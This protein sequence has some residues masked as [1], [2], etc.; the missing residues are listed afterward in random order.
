MRTTVAAACAAL[1]VSALALPAAAADPQSLP[2]NTIPVKK[3]TLFYPGESTYEWLLSPAHEKANVRV[4]QGRS[5]TSCH[6]E[7]DTKDLGDKLVKAGPLE[8]NPIPGKKGTIDLQVQAAHDAEYLYLRAQWK[9][10]MNREG[11]MHDYVRFDGQKW[12]WYGH[13]RNDKKVRSGAEP[14]LYEDRF[15][16]MLDD[17]KVARFAE[18]GCWL[19][20]HNGMRDTPGQALGDPVKRHPLLGD[21]GLKASD[22]RKYLPSTRTGPD[23]RWDQTRSAEEIA[24]LKADGAFL[25]LMQWR[26]AR[27]APVGMADDGYVL[28]YRNFDDG[29]N[30]FSGNMDAKTMT[31]KFM[32]DPAKVGAKAL[33]AR[34]IGDPAKPAAL[35]REANA[36]PYDPNA[37]WK[38]GDIL[39]G[40]LLSRAD[41]KGSA[42]DNDA[43]F[44]TWK[45]GTYTVVWRRKL[46]TGNADDKQ[47]KVGGRYTIG[48][49][50]HDDNVTTRFHH[51]S[52]PLSLGIGVD[53]DVRATTLR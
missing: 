8:P 19:T 6:D 36:V 50:V 7:E 10:Q 42:A 31:P 40:R 49:A 51:V 4:A 12:Q 18:Q 14:P 52:F 9:S 21:S 1:S 16:I 32:F 44:G 39:P 22:V 25:D 43:V 13:D 35:V 20:C 23:A 47:L 3:V 5:C 33:Q 30:P 53:A 48:I 11:R 24:K 45:D 26:V 15:S 2:W 38:E 34:D 41:A 37:G 29:K 27:S 17:G 28:E 46:N